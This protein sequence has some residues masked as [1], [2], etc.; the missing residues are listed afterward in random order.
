MSILRKGPAKSHETSALIAG[1]AA[2]STWGLIPV[3][4]KLLNRVSAPEI[5]AHRFVWTSLFLIGLLTWQGRWPE[6]KAVVRSRRATLFCLAAGLAVATN[7]FFF[8]FAVNIG[9]VIE[10]S[11]GYFMT[12]LVNVLFGAIFLRERLTRLQIISVL[13]ATVGVL[14][15]TFGYGRF[16]WIAV[17]LCTTFG[18]YGLLRKKSGTASIPGLFLETIMLVPAALAYLVL[19]KVSGRLL[20]DRS[21]WLLSILLISTGVV[22]AV[23]LFWFGYAARYLRLTTVGFLQYLAPTG[24]FFLGVFLYHEPFT[25]GHLITFSLI[26][27]ALAIFTFEAV[28]RWRSS[29]VRQALEEV[30][31]EP[32]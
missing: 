13:V 10:T 20:F 14:Y 9:R 24:S 12:P 25:R 11:L 27:I 7:W 17:T 23:P 3:Y 8:I 6:V 4:W 29:R 1:I 22:T 18:L 5:L 26:W 21:G 15:L 16:P 31:C 28:A 32:V 2:F 30:V 19:L